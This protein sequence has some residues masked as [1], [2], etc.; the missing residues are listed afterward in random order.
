MR[1]LRPWDLHLAAEP[2][3]RVQQVCQATAGNCSSMLQDVLARRPTEI[4][5]INGQIVAHGQQLQIP[6]PVN[7][8]LFN[9]I[10]ALESGFLQVEN[11]KESPP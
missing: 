3:S 10:K 1:W 6:T 11:G 2:V 5:A 9:L 8:L 4:E 7:T